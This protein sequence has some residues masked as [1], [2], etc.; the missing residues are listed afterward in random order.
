MLTM[1]EQFIRPEL[2]RRVIYPAV[3][4]LYGA[5]AMTAMRLGTRRA[6]IIHKMVPRAVEECKGARASGKANSLMTSTR[7]SATELVSGALP[8]RLLRFRRAP[9]ARTG[10]ASSGSPS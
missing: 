10:P 8:L 7:S 5:G 3:G 1:L 9:G 2:A 6:G 4:G